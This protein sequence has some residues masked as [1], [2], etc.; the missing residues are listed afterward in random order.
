MIFYPKPRNYVDHFLL[1]AHTV[2][3]DELLAEQETCVD[4]RSPHVCPSCGRRRPKGG[5]VQSIGR[6]GV[7]RGVSRGQIGLE[8]PR[9]QDAVDRLGTEV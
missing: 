8:P 4:T 2:G 7:F 9:R 6:G 5:L 3:G 1:G